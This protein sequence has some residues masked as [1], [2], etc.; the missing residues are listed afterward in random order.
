MANYWIRGFQSQL[1]EAAR[2][3]DL[4]GLMRL[5]KAVLGRSDAAGHA[6]FGPGELAEILSTVNRN[7][8]VA[9]AMDDAQLKRLI[10]KA[11]ACGIVSEDSTRRCLRRA[12]HMWTGGRPGSDRSDCPVHRVEGGTN[13]SPLRAKRGTNP[14]PQGGPI[15]PPRSASEPQHHAESATSSIDSSPRSLPTDWTWTAQHQSHAQEIGKDWLDLDHLAG[16]FREFFTSRPVRRTDWDWEFSQWID[17]EK[18]TRPEFVKRLDAE[19]EQ[20]ERAWTQQQDNHDGD[21]DPVAIGSVIEHLPI[22]AQKHIA[23][24]QARRARREQALRTAT[25]RAKSA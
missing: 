3:P 10:K 18:D 21:R 11:K 9:S 22:G 6:Q 25:A 2:N 14:S 23:A 19:R 13:P 17:A 7:T 16:K 20:A 4:P 15:R 8:G 12:S 1:T 5:E 24:A